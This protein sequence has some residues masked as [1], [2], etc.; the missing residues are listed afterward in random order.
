MLAAVVVARRSPSH[1]GGRGQQSSSVA[2]ASLLQWGRVRKRLRKKD[3]GGIGIGFQ[4]WEFFE[5]KCYLF[6]T[7]ISLAND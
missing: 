4:I 7:N 5:F 3:E 1:N 6:V 2:V